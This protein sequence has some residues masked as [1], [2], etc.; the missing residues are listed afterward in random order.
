MIQVQPGVKAANHTI[1]LPAAPSPMIRSMMYFMS[2]GA[3][4]LL[5]MALFI[6]VTA[7]PGT[8]VTILPLFNG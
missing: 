2:F 4:I 5:R 1:F 7:L 6:V 8:A 3:L